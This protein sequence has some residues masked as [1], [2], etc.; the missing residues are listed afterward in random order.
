MHITSLS[1]NAFRNHA[2]LKLRDLPSGLIAISGPNGIGKT[3]ILEAIS[4]LSPGRGLRHAD[5]A[6]LQAQHMDANTT[7]WS[8]HTQLQG[9]YGPQDMGM[10]F[11]PVSGRR[12]VKLNGE[13]IKNQ[14]DRNDLFRCVWL[15]P[16]QDRLFM[17]A[18]SSRRKFLDRWVFSNDSAHAGRISRLDR[19][20]AER[21]RLL[22][23][24]SP[25]P[26][27][28]D[29]LEQDLSETSL[30]IAVAR[31]DY[32]DRLR[33]QIDRYQD[34][35]FPQPDIKLSGFLEDQIG[36][37][38][39]LAIEQ[40]YRTALKQNRA[41]DA[42]L[43]ATTIGPHRSD[44]MVTYR[45]KNMP[46][47]E[48]STGEQKA[49]LFALFLAH[50]RLIRDEWGETP[51]LLLDEM[52]AHLDPARRDALLG[53]LHDLQ[54]QTFLSATTRDACGTHSAIHHVTLDDIIAREQRVA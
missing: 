45:A 42:S 40:D 34:A 8:L 53:L 33:H 4:L 31:T 10:G 12:L 37:E 11:D 44:M 47:S 38:P 17:D 49:L 5:T 24:P 22:A 3:N 1:L 54:C 35:E 28:L 7:P 13:T 30:A 36:H 46:A 41:R 48:C 16:A 32:L 39:A 27:W 20:L 9:R 15:T 19:L 26:L 25:D 52:T 29:A 43:E 50:T 18:A 51:V 14:D 6:D 21:N 23:T 2:A